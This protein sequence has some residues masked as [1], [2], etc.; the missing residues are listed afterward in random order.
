[1]MNK[2]NVGTLSILAIAVV[3]IILVY[4]EQS[5]I[6]LAGLVIGLIVGAILFNVF[7]KS[8][9]MQGIEMAYKTHERVMQVPVKMFQEARMSQ[10]EERIGGLHQESPAAEGDSKQLVIPRINIRSG[11]E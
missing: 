7:A 8:Y 6:F 3:V 4:P 10:R 5:S 9:F 2:A 11:S 1:M